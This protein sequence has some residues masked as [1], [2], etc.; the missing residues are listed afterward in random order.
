MK[1]FLWS[2]EYQ[3]ATSHFSNCQAPFIP[4]P[5]SLNLT[6]TATSFA[7]NNAYLSLYFYLK[8]DISHEE[9][10]LDENV[11][12]HTIIV[13]S[14]SPGVHFEKLFNFVNAIAHFRVH[15]VLL[16]TVIYNDSKGI[17]EMIYRITLNI[18][19][20]LSDALSMFDL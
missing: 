16:I 19:F 6:N 8:G 3:W 13:T 15:Q 18:L 1:N 11:E 9:S 14:W 20:T 7:F 17:L 5:L 2:H 10:R 12:Y 4:A